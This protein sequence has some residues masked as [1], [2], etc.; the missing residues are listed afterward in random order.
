MDW[1]RVTAITRELVLPKIADQIGKTSKGFGRFLSMAKKKNGGKD[2]QKVVKYR[3]NAQGGY[4]AGLSMLKTSQEQTKT[5]ATFVWTQAYQAIVLSNIELAKNGITA[6]AAEGNDVKVADLMATEMEDAQEALKDRL[7]TAFYGD[8]TVN[9]EG[10]DTMDGLQAAIDDG[11]NVA[12]YGSIDRTVYT[13]WKANYTDVSGALTTAA[14]ATIYDSCENGG[15]S[16]DLILTT[17]AIWSDYEALMQAQIRFINED[18]SAN[19]MDIGGGTLAFRTTPVVKDEYCPA[20]KMFFVNTSTFELCFMDHPNHPTD[21]NGFAMRP[22]REPDS[23]DGQVGFIFFYHQLVCI[24]PRAN[25][26]LDNIS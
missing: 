9:A 14:M 18:G 21:E 2:I 3:H 1:D 13:W 4:Y 24:E 7:S 16:P 6:A 15:K 23:Q 20:G 17:K 26:Q 11:T 10:Y 19:N 25:G 8:G 22:L 5:R 12:T